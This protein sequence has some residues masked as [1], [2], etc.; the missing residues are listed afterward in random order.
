MMCYFFLNPGTRIW[1][2]VSIKLTQNTFPYLYLRI[3]KFNK[4][5]ESL[6]ANNMTQ[7]L[8]QMIIIY[9]SSIYASNYSSYNVITDYV[10]ML[11]CT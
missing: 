1:A 9:G 11:V 3:K 5:F 6:Y 10:I 7:V 4:H 8:V 2:S